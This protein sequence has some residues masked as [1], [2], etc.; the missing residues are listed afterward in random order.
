MLK[1]FARLRKF[2][3]RAVPAQRQFGVR[4]L[5]VYNCRHLYKYV[6]LEL[7][8]FAGFGGT[9]GYLWQSSAL[10]LV[11]ISYQRRSIWTGWKKMPVTAHSCLCACIKLAKTPPCRKC[12]AQRG[13]ASCT[14]HPSQAFFLKGSSIRQAVQ[15]IYTTQLYH[16]TRLRPKSVQWKCERWVGNKSK[17]TFGSGLVFFA[18]CFVNNSRDTYHR[19]FLSQKITEIISIWYQQM[20]AGGGGGG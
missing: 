18:H 5:R 16:V 2:C 13:D 6:Y 20:K 12:H 4:Y 17:K 10:M 14:A 1:I 15:R 11:L 9:C 3:Q 7:K 19:G 8:S